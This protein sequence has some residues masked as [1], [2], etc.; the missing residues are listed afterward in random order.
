M[1]LVLKAAVIHFSYSSDYKSWE[2]CL[3]MLEN[4]KVKLKEFTN[5]RYG[6]DQWEQ[7]FEAARSGKYLKVIINP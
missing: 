2:S 4:E 1:S 6:L 3:S 7:A 5:K